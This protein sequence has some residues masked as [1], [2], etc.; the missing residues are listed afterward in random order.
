MRVVFSECAPNYDAHLA[1]YQVL[2]FPD[3]GETAATA[4]SHGMLPSNRELTR[5]YLA[6]SVRVDL[7]RYTESKRE[8][9]IRRQCDTLSRSFLPRAQ[10]TPQDT[11][12]DM[13]VRYM[14]ESSQWTSRR[15]RQFETADMVARL[16]T[17]MT[18]HL[19]TLTDTSNQSPAALAALYVEPPIAYYARACYD[20]R[21]RKLSVGSHLMS[22]A[23]GELQRRGFSHV[24]LGTCYYEGA[25][26]K[27]RF[28]GMEFFDGLGWSDDRERLRLLLS[29]QDD[30]RSRHLFDHP[31]YLAAGPPPRPGDATMRLTDIA[32]S[33]H[34]DSAEEQ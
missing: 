32:N 20:A 19:L 16:D 8:R 5:F 12:L 17:P 2:G 9:Y 15:G 4:F 34:I 13:C 3:E 30:L 21:Y 24:Y 18:T 11:W 33:Q 28:T 14:N 22:C 6:R 10:L 25:R 29:Q 27:T 31:S 1:P 26:Y 7:G 23:I